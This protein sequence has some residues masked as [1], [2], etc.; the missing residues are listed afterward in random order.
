M[1]ILFILL[2]LFISSCNN[3]IKYIDCINCNGK[4]KNTSHNEEFAE[5]VVEN[6]KYEEISN[7]LQSD[8]IYVFQTKIKNLS[9]E[10][11]KFM[12]ENSLIFNDIGIKQI[13]CE[14]FINSGELKTIECTTTIDRKPHDFKYVVKAPKY[15]KSE[16]K[17]CFNCNGTGKVVDK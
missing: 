8:Y 5:F 11:G 1:K 3:E 14:D 7:F 10:R 17:V 9:D 13:I 2:T 4:G 15:I 16:E 6:A 12:I